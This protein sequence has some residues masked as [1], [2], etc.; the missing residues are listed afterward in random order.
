[1]MMFIITLTVLLLS[2]IMYIASCLLLWGITGQASWLVYSAVGFS[3]VLFG[4]AVQES[5]LSFVPVRSFYGMCNVPTKYYP[6]VLMIA[7]QVIMPNI[8]L[9]GHLCGAVVGFLHVHGHL[10]WIMPSNDAAKVLE[11]WGCLQ[12]IVRRPNFV[13]GPDN[14]PKPE[15]ESNACVLLG[16]CVG[17]VW[18]GLR[19][20]T[21]CAWNASVGR[22]NTA[23]RMA[24]S[25]QEAESAATAPAAP[26]YISDQGIATATSPTPSTSASASAQHSAAASAPQAQP[27]QAGGLGPRPDVLGDVELAPTSRFGLGRPPAPSSR[28]SKDVSG[29]ELE[30][31]PLIAPEGAAGGGSSAASAPEDFDLLQLGSG[32]PETSPISPSPAGASAPAGQQAPSASGGTGRALGGPQPQAGAGNPQGRRTGRL[33]HSRLLSGGKR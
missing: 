7:I 8:S 33:A 15:G 25:A 14:L 21:A 3:G 1:M 11:T 17:F 13:L 2:N 10:W 12:C 24:G 22:L 32:G 4:F 16:G 31:E 6:W 26:R 18:S 9:L 27:P 29:S 30:Q 23:W 5:S 28:R 19:P 20:M